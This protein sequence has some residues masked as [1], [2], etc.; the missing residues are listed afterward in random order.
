MQT[1]PTTVQTIYLSTALPDNWV[2]AQEGRLLDER[3]FTRLI[4]YSANVY[5]PNGS[6]LG[7]FRRGVLPLCRAY[8]LTGTTAR[9]ALPEINRYQM[10]SNVI[11]YFDRPKCRKTS[12][13]RTQVEKWGQCLPFIRA[14]NHVFRRHEPAR[15]AIQRHCALKTVPDD[16]IAD[17][18]FTTVT[19]NTWD[20]DYHVQ[21][22]VH[23]DAGDLPEGLWSYHRSVS[24][25]TTP[26]ATSMF[27]QVPS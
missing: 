16:A 5:T 23:K 15:Y 22:P 6:L 21:T 11:G 8:W 10:A 14:C 25:V 17:T 3:Y 24:P 1:T 2:E 12:F 26:V 13:M 7:R 19:V 9:R 27:P 18:A 4:D 20:K